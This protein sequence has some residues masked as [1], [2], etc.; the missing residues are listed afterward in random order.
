MVRLRVI[1]AERNNKPEFKEKCRQG[2]A[3]QSWW[4]NGEVSKLARECPGP[5]WSRGSMREV[6]GHEWV[7]EKR[8]ERRKSKVINK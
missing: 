7:L 8:R 5:E 4:N 6:Y 1:T 3:Q 2:R